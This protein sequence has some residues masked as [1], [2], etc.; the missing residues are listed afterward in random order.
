MA[1]KE[2][3]PT[4]DYDGALL[5]LHYRVYT[6][7]LHHHVV[8]CHLCQGQKR[9][10]EWHLLCW[11]DRLQS[12]IYLGSV[13][14]QDPKVGSCSWNCCRLPH[15]GHPWSFRGTHP[16]SGGCAASRLKP[17]TTKTVSL[18]RQVASSA[19]S[20]VRNSR[21]SICLDINIIIYYCYCCIWQMPKPTFKIKH[22][23]EE[24]TPMSD[25]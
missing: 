18:H 23:Q 17:H 20:R 8:C 25:Q 6:H 5:H 11:G 13:D 16:Q 7:L 15:L 1:A 22:K 4:K 12:D 2:V 9:N 14:F 21:L 24:T 19:I 3:Q 10:A